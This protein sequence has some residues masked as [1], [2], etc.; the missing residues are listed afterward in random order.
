MKIFACALAVAIGSSCLGQKDDPFADVVVLHEMGTNPAAGYDQPASVLG[1][2]ERFTGEGIFPGVVSAFNPPW[3]VDEIF[4][5]GAGG[6]IIVQFDTPITDDPDN[7]HGIDLLVFG[8]TGFDGGTS[9]EVAVQG[10][11]GNDG[12]TIEVSADGVN[13]HRVKAVAADGLMP[14]AGYADAGPYDAAPGI[15]FTDFTRPVDPRLTLDHM[16][17]LTNAQVM[18]LYRGSGGGAGVD[19]GTAG[20]GITQVSFVR[21]ANPE[22]ATEHIEIDAL[23]DV[24]P[25]KPGD[26]NLDDA[27]N[28]QDLL[29]A[30][31]AWGISEPG[32]APADFNLD[33]LVN[34]H[35]LLWVIAHWG[36]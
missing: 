25:R 5:I 17:G 32:D 19:I 29:L 7:L 9:S 18:E 12:G 30:I 3:G 11:F 34:V 16:M 23:S 28:V 31:G 24:A 1:S 14:T 8:N 33:G 27:V 21:I 26:V 35:D 13:W 36:Q 10:L 6:F 2:P 20:S 22:G 15:V 4:S